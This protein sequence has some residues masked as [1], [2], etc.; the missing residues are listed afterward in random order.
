MPTSVPDG[1]WAK[2]PRPGVEVEDTPATRL[3]YVSNVTDAVPGEPKVQK[4]KGTVL[5]Q[6]GAA[7][8]ERWELA[9]F[10]RRSWGLRISSGI[11]SGTRPAA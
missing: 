11:G 6:K 8:L 10:T 3:K 1:T 7:P 5:I 4:A 9:H 2:I